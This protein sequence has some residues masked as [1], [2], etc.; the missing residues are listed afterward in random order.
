MVSTELSNTMTLDN[1]AM[2]KVFEFFFF[3]PR[4]THVIGF[5]RYL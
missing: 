2:A 3:G 1:I 5:L 4:S